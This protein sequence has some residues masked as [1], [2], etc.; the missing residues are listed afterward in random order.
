MSIGNY[1]KELDTIIKTVL[2]RPKEG[3]YLPKFIIL[4]S[5]AGT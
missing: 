5:R 1:F 3:F 4:A 2:Q